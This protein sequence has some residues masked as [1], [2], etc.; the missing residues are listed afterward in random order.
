[1]LINN[2]RNSVRLGSGSLHLLLQSYGQLP[3]LGTIP[4]TQCP[5]LQIV[6]IFIIGLA[7]QWVRNVPSITIPFRLLKYV[8]RF[9]REKSFL[10]GYP[11]IYVVI[12][13]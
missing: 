4:L 12:M 8:S 7:D 1:M 3:P 13:K 11:W 5:Q 2:P 6:V 9:L 10:T